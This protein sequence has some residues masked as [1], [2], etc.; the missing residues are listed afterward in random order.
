MANTIKLSAMVVGYVLGTILLALSIFM[1]FR[2]TKIARI[3]DLD[4]YNLD[5]E[6]SKSVD[7]AL[8]NRSEMS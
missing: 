3:E 4:D 6:A 1:F 8:I 5:K 2:M 7:R